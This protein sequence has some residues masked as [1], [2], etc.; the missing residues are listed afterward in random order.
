MVGEGRI[1]ENGVV[2]T[3]DKTNFL[4][5]E[6]DAEGGGRVNGMVY[7]VYTLDDKAV[8]SANEVAAMA[9]VSQDDF[10]PKSPSEVSAYA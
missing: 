8:M 10:S 9:A 6:M 2:L 3:M 4:M 7:G 1:I 5:D